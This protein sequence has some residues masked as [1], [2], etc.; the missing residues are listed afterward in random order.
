QEIMELL[1]A[2]VGGNVAPFNGDASDSTT[3][4]FSDPLPE[5]AAS[6]R[7]FCFTGKFN[8]GT[9]D[10]CCTQVIDR[11][12]FA[13][14]SVTKKVNFLVIGE[15]GSRDWLHSTYGTK[16]QKAIDY[17]DQGTSLHI[18]GEQHWY[19]QVIGA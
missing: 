4:P 17:R 15:V 11:G 8:S 5:V 13:T 12:G 1:L 3:L 14:N 16:I 18:I 19:E 2:A 7:T 6:G 9:R 10:W